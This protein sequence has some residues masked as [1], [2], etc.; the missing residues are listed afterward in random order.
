MTTGVQ[1]LADQFKRLELHA[2]RGGR[3]VRRVLLDVID[4]QARSELFTTEHMLVA[5]QTEI[6]ALLPA[7]PP[8]APPFRSM[9]DLLVGLEH[10]MAAGVG[11]AQAFAGLQ[12]A[13]G[14]QA[15]ADPQQVAE[16]AA[17]NLL[18][19]LPA[20]ASLYTH[21]LSETVL[22]VIRVLHR[23]GRVAQV[24]VTESRPNLDGRQTA[25]R[26]AAEGVRTCLTVDA[27]MPAAIRG[28]DLMLTGAEAIDAG[29]HVVGKVG[30]FPAAVFCRLH[31]KPVFVVADSNK[32]FPLPLDR[33]PFT[34]IPAG[35]LYPDCAADE[36]WLPF[37]SYFDV[38]PGEYI[39]RYV[40][41]SGVLP[42]EEIS[43]LAGGLPVSPW[44]KAKFGL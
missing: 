3:E 23:M 24:F 19:Y 35:D 27:A 38:T 9:N 21:T 6:N 29:G 4:P 44:L 15:G 14:Q 36:Q 8:Y 5:L 33:L 17:Q 12:K 30:A 18:A 2:A 28:A 39:H 32:L 34:P 7:L 1:A 22:N 42:I 41:E 26:L 20:C 43:R 25:Q 37:G 31:G 11:A 13:A 16:Q 40:T 10:S